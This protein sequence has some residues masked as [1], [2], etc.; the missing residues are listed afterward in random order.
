MKIDRSSLGNFLTLCAAVTLV[1]LAAHAASFLLLAFVI[2]FWFFT[3]DLVSVQVP[4]PQETCKAD[5]FPI[6]RVFSPRPPPLN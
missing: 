5:P 6:L 3:F 2:P 4:I 1:L